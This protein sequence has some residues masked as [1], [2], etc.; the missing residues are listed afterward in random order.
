VPPH[1]PTPPYVRLGAAYRGSSILRPEIKTQKQIDTM[2]RGAAIA[3]RVRAFA[4]SLVKVCG[5]ARCPHRSRSAAPPLAID[6]QAGVDSVRVARS[7][8]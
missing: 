8:A 2:R 4:G 1:I 3:S 6:H 5:P 7:R